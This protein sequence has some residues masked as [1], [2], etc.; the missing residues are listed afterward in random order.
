MKL[1]TNSFI[2]I[3]LTLITGL[4]AYAA[5]KQK[6]VSEL[7]KRFGGDSK[8]SQAELKVTQQPSHKFKSL[9]ELQDFYKQEMADQEKMLLDVF[10]ETTGVSPKEFESKKLIIRNELY[11]GLWGYKGELDLLKKRYAQN[12]NHITKDNIQPTQDQQLLADKIITIAKKVFHQEGIPLPEIFFDHIETGYGL[13]VTP[14]FLKVDMQTAQHETDLELQ[15][16]ILHEIGHLKYDDAPIKSTL[17]RF[18]ILKN[19]TNFEESF[20]QLWSFFIEKRADIY[21]ATRGLEYAKGIIEYYL[22]PLYK[23]TYYREQG[24]H[25]S[26]ANR[27]ALAQQIYNEILALPKKE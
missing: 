20:M 13:E 18:S 19:E 21:A 2:I 9:K 25:Q 5:E 6:P 23:E 8:L 10:F 16:G 11:D 1:A 14:Y 12:K 3:S 17:R 7:I 22:S 4:S 27:A 24:T 26:P 15:A